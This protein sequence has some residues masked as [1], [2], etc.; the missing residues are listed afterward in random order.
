MK[1]LQTS[2]P[3]V[4]CE[5]ENV[6]DH[7]KLQIPYAGYKLAWE[8]RFDSNC[9]TYA[10]D[11]VFDDD[12]FNLYLDADIISQRVPALDRWDIEIPEC[13]STVVQQ[14]LNVYTLYQLQRMV[15]N[16]DYFGFFII[17]LQLPVLIEP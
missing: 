16:L 12:S 5:H 2:A 14:L 17:V 3:V 13:L 11:F 15:M 10:P 1:D 6:C 4:Y 9:P 8:V 7:F